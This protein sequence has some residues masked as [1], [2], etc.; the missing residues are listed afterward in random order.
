MEIK[1][2]L[3]YFI[4]FKKQNIFNQLETKLVKMTVK[5]SYF[6]LELLK[7]F[8]IKLSTILILSSTVINESNKK[9]LTS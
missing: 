7:F 1:C 9:T 3:V 8:H 2:L 4:Y 6:K 5:I